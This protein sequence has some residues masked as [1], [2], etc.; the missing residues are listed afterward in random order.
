MQGNH[1]GLRKGG[2]TL[3][4]KPN[5]CAVDLIYEVPAAQTRTDCGLC[6]QA[7][8]FISHPP[9]NWVNNRDLS[10]L[11]MP[12]SAK[13][14]L[15]TSITVLRPLG[16]VVPAFVAE[17]YL[18]FSTRTVAIGSRAFEGSWMSTPL[19]DR[20]IFKGLRSWSASRYALVIDRA[21]L[22]TWNVPFGQVKSSM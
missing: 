22:S 19:P 2:S 6:I 21:N 10:G 4:T 18:V 17:V 1:Q 9:R 11:A 15:G 5:C 13:P 20:M 12:G 3:W 7:G 8:N 14:P 16:G